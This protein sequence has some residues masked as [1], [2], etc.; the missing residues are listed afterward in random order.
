VFFASVAAASGGHGFS[1]YLG[2]LAEQELTTRGFEVY[3]PAHALAGQHRDAF[4]PGVIAS[5]RGALGRASIIVVPF[6]LPDTTPPSVEAALALE[7]AHDHD[8]VAFLV[9]ATDEAVTLEE[10]S[11]HFGLMGAELTP[12]ADIDAQMHG[13]PIIDAV[14]A[15]V[16]Q[17]AVEQDNPADPPTS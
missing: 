5:H 6:G 10:A 16:E 15:L 14:C 2:V 8:D 3:V 13:Q 9:A 7:Y 11:Q 4:A 17:A 12:P 1:Q